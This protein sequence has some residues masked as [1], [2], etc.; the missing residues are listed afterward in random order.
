MAYH[1][2]VKVVGTIIKGQ[3]CLGMNKDINVVRQQAV[4]TFDLQKE[5]LAPDWTDAVTPGYV[6][7]IANTDNPNDK[8]LLILSGCNDQQTK[9][10]QLL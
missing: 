1:L 4:S 8:V 7:N 5:S 10:C 6:I 3:H 9:K 2:I